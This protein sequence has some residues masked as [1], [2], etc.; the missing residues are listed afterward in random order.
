MATSFL[1]PVDG[2]PRFPVEVFERIIESAY[3]DRYGLVQAAVTT[4]SSCSVVCRAWRP[5]AQKVLFEYVTLR[6][7]PSL[8]RFAELVDG[9]PDL[10]SF[11]RRLSLRGYLHVS[12]SP[13]VTFPT[14]LGARLTNLRV[15]YIVEI[16]DHEKASKPLSEGEKELPILPIHPYLPSLL[17]S[18]P[19]IRRLD[20]VKLRF[21]S[22]GDFA[23][24]L[25]TL[26]SLEELY[27]VKVSWAV[28][29]QTPYCLTRNR[30]HNSLQMFLP[31]LRFLRVRLYRNHVFWK[32]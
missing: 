7:M 5:H 12:F 30:S 24:V 11:V 29:G 6:D 25:H 16:S 20:L 3:D 4:L 26:S 13:V 22:F 2:D 27:C 15:L 23:R 32:D 9:S 28:L 10:G 1:L 31:E 18:I 17:T 8:Y 21:P 19:P 14:I